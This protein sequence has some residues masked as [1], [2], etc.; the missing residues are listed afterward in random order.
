[1]RLLLS[2]LLFTGSLLAGNFSFCLYFNKE[3]CGTRFDNCVDEKT[4]QLHPEVLANADYDSNGL[5]HLLT[6]SG[7]YYFTS[8][9]Y[10]QR[11]HT[12]DNGPDYFEEGLARMIGENGK[13]GYVNPKL[14]I[15]IEPA[16]DFAYPFRNGRAIVCN[17]CRQVREGEH[18]VSQGGQWGI[19]DPKGR[20]IQPITYTKDAF[21][22]RFSWR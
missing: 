2:L 17:G 18:F 6:S 4:G 16:F 13:I 8:K 15:V 3:E 10:F 20:S 9:G 11:M 7:S 21:F 22:S 1:M 5:G 14:E 12:F 19:I